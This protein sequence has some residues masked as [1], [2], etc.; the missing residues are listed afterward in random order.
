MRDRIV[1]IRHL[2]RYAARVRRGRYLRLVSSPLIR[3]SISHTMGTEATPSRPPPSF[4]KCTCGP[5]EKRHFAG[6]GDSPE[7]NQMARRK[8]TPPSTPIV[9]RYHIVDDSETDDVISWTDGGKHFTIHDVN[10]FA[11][12]ILSKYFKLLVQ[13]ICEAAELLRASPARV[14]RAPRSVTAPAFPV[15][16]DVRGVRT[17]R[18][19]ARRVDQRWD[20]GAA[21]PRNLARSSLTNESSVPLRS[22]SS[23]S[24]GFYKV[25]HTCWTFSNNNF[26]KG[27]EENLVNIRRRANTRHKPNEPNEVPATSS[28][29]PR[30]ANA[31]PRPSPCPVLCVFVCSTTSR[32]GRPSPDPSNPGYGGSVA[33]GV[34]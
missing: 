24:Q 1:A 34:G 2:R 20:P 10:E 21:P 8:L 17:E 3:E 31:S 18:N 5:R 33:G 16:L 15:S 7:W 4:A 25:K 6:G 27:Q 28:D 9:R 32:P 11:A 23:R 19:G 12:Q 13:L 30:R 26:V 29:D 14:A 22:S